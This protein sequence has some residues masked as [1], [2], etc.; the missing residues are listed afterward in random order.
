MQKNPLTFTAVGDAI[1]TQKFSVY[2]EE[3]FNELIDQIQDQDVSVANLEVLLHNFE[4]YPA[5]Q[6]GGTYMQAPPEIADELEWAGFNL[7]SA[8]TNHAGDFSHGGMEATMQALEERNMSYAGM[9]RN[10]AQ[11]RAPTYLDTPKGRVALI[12]ACT[13]ITTGTEAGLQRPDMQGR[14][15]ISPLHLQTRYTVPEEFHEELIHASKKLGL[16]AIK[17]RKRE[18]GF[19]V[20][21]EDSD[22]F[23]FLNIGGETDIQFELGDRFDIHQEVNDEDAESIT[24]QIQAAKRQADWVFIS[25]HSHE[26]TGGS[27]ND[28]TVPQ[29]L[30]S[31]ARNCIDAGADGFIGHGPH[32]LRGIEIYRGAPIFYSLG[33]FFMQNETIPNLPA[34]IYDRYDLD[35]YQ[36]LP[37]DLFDERIFNDEQQRQGFTADRKFW[38]S[39]LPICEF[40]EDGVES[41]E[42]LPLDLGYERSRPQRGRPMLAGPDVTDH[43]FATVNELSSQYGTEFTEDGP[44]LRVDL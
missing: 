13:T 1:V 44:V 30:E 26:G 25:L 8:A 22:G 20:P 41:I 36:S 35:P 3:S 24:K 28:D 21:G 37:A 34:E 4:G 11:A 23:T 15:G 43:V 2:E 17:D 9:G 38:E 40:G 31:F 12:S 5:A 33:N 7:F 6:S 19:Q 27:R 32:V 10:L 18:L 14:P 16:E 29:F 39:V 42:L